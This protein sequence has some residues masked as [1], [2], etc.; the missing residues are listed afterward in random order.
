[1][2]VCL[3]HFLVFLY[4]FVFRVSRCPGLVIAVEVLGKCFKAAWLNAPAIKIRGLFCFF[5]CLIGWLV[6]CI[7]GQFCCKGRVSPVSL[8]NFNKKRVSSCSR[9]CREYKLLNHVTCLCFFFLFLVFSLSS[10]FA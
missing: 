10:F 2:K 9:G 1:M 3:S 8:C 7:Y 6:L 5:F 4:V